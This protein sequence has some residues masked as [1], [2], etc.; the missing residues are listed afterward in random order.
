MKNTL[1]S[2]ALAGLLGIA[3]EG[4]VPVSNSPQPW[5]ER[6]INFYA[7]DVLMPNVRDGRSKIE[8]RGILWDFDNDGKVD[9]VANENRWIAM[10]ARSYE[11]KAK[12]KNKAKEMSKI[13]SEKAPIHIELLDERTREDLTRIYQAQRDFQRN[14][15]MSRGLYTTNS[16]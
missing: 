16:F 7:G 2:I 13:H 15:L 5:T 11:N 12:E 1:K 10:V 3:G 8:Y 9:A 14:Y 4:C 6:E